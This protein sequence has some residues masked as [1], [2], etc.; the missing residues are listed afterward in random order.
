MKKRYFTVNEAK[1]E[2]AHIGT[3]IASTSEEL[4]NKLSEA[5]CAHFDAKVIGMSDFNIDDCL[6]GETLDVKI[7]LDCDLAFPIVVTIS[8]TWLY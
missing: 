3:L 7:D 5:C 1:G 2:C 6:Y 8:E 4:K